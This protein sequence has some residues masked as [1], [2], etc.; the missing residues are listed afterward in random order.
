M[1]T[2]EQIKED[3]AEIKGFESWSELTFNLS[4]ISTEKIMDEICVIYN[5]E[6]KDHYA[7]QKGFSSWN[8]LVNSHVIFENNTDLDNHIKSI[9]ISQFEKIK[10]YPSNMFNED[11]WVE[12]YEKYNL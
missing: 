3:Y 12:F 4:S 1:K 11:D 10:G 8:H 6:H 5:L 2:L 9:R 7:K